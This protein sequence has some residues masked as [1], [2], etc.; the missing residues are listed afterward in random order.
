MPNMSHKP[1][2]PST[3]LEPLDEPAA[4]AKRGPRS[5]RARYDLEKLP[6]FTRPFDARVTNLTIFRKAPMLTSGQQMFVLID[7]PPVVGR[8]QTSAEGQLEH[9]RAGKCEPIST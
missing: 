3:T 2:T 9:I 5:K 8:G 4:G 6:R 7:A 1:P